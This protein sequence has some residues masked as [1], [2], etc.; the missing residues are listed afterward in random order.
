MAEQITK[1]R[2]RVGLGT[3]ASAAYTQNR[4]QNILRYQKN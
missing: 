2:G 3:R 1:G 4:L